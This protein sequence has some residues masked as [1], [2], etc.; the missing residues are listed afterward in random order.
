MAGKITGSC[1]CGR[2]VYTIP[3][4][5]DMNLCHCIDCRKWAGAMHSAHL[6][7]QTADIETTSPE[8]RTYRQKADSGNE[9]TRA[10]CDGCGAGVWLRSASKPG[11]TFLKAGL[12]EPGDI[13]NPTM[14]N[15]LKNME[16]WET[17][18]RGTKKTAQEGLD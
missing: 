16:P 6:L 14:E 8:P 4:P 9:M 3:K 15:W 13:P 12:F 17:P 5:A 18:A 11:L 2:H 10:W 1:N 7:V